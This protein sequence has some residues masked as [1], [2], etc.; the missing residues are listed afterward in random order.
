MLAL[1]E[2]QKCK[3][4]LIGKYVMGGRLSD[5]RPG[6]VTHSAQNRGKVFPAELEDRQWAVAGHVPDVGT[7]ALGSCGQKQE[8]LHHKWLWFGLTSWFGLRMACF[9]WWR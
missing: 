2:I 4:L 3:Q 8:Q 5:S 6:G 1:L 9:F 7:E